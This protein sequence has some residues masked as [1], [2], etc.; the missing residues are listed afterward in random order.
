MHHVTGGNS[1][2]FSK[3]TDSPFYNPNPGRQKLAAIRAV[4]WDCE[5]V[6]LV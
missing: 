4:Q 1:Y 6:Y 2:H 5:I 3:A